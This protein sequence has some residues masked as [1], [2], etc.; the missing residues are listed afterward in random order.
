MPY[1]QLS[2]ES[3]GVKVLIFTEGT[4]LGPRNALEHFSVSRYVPIGCC[5]SLI[6]LWQEQ[7]ADIQYIT[8]RKSRKAVQGVQALLERYGFAGSR[9]YFRARGQ[10]YHELV[11]QIRPDVL[12][13]DDC[14]SIGGENQMCVTHVAPEIRQTIHSISVPE[15]QG[16]DH[17]PESLMELSEYSAR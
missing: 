17:L 2:E 12:I 5:V 13:E 4:V 9:L 3:V 10:Q 8:S 11:E 1:I 7:G 15:F 6:R 16:I 14:R